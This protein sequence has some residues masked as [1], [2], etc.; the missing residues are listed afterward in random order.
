MKQRIGRYWRSNKKL[1]TAGIV[2]AVLLLGAVAAW[3]AEYFINVE[4]QTEEINGALFVGFFPDTPTG[5]GNFDPFLRIR[6]SNLNIVQGF[7]TNA[8]PQLDFIQMSGVRPHN[9]AHQ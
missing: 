6:Q 2:I 5:T 4:G 1:T 3:A 8:A 7:N 9:R